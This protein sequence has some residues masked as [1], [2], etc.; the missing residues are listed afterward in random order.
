M[1]PRSFN[2]YSSAP[3][4][5]ASLPD[6]IIPSKSI[7]PISN[8]EAGLLIDSFLSFQDG[9]ILTLHRL[10]DHLQGR[11]QSADNK[12]I[13]EFEHVLE[14]ERRRE[15]GIVQV[16]PDE[17]VDGEMGDM[18]GT[19]ERGGEEV[20]N[21]ETDKKRARKEERRLKKEREREKRKRDGNEDDNEMDQG[22]ES[23]KKAK[24]ETKSKKTKEKGHKKEK[25]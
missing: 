23:E 2:P 9:K 18:E 13:E 20:P 21:I 17:V 16:Q 6:Y 14:E 19:Q 1:P 24:K 3:P 22:G 10:A 7:Q 4:P 8:A 11:T 15:G 25:H 5:P 12:E